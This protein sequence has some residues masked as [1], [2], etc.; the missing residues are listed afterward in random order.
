MLIHY[1]LKFAIFFRTKA[2]FFICMKKS[3]ICRSLT[4]IS[5]WIVGLL[6]NYNQLKT[7]HV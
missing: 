3:C 6:C 7:A 1:Y 2:L 4:S 5:A